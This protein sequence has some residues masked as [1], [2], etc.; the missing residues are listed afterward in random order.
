MKKRLLAC[1]LTLSMVAVTV[2]GCGKAKDQ[3]NSQT[4]TETTPTTAVES[5][6]TT[7]PA[8]AEPSKYQTTYGSKMFDDVTITVELF[9]RS[10]APEGSTITDNRWTEYVQQEMKKVGINVE[11]VTV[12]RWDEVTKMQT[13]MASGTAPDITLT[14]T[15]AY[16]EQYLND[17]GI[18]DLSEFINADDQATNMKAY[19][20]ED[21]LNIGKTQDNQLY[22]IVA[23]RATTAKSNLF[24]RKDWLDKL[25][26]TVPTTPDELYNV[27]YAMKYSN[28]DA[29]NS[30]I[31]AIISNAWNM[32]LAFSQ[33]AGNEKEAAISFGD[34]AIGD[35]YD[36]GNRE[37]YRFMNKLY[38]DGLLNK[39]YY[40]MTD[41]NFKSYIATGDVAFFES[42][43]NFAVD[44][45]RGSLLKTLQENVPDADIVS[46][47]PLKNAFDGKQYS[48]SYA[49]GGLIAF[50]PLTAD[51]DKV[52]ACMTYL[53]WQCTQDGGF[54]LYHG[55]EGEHF[56]Y[57]ADG[58]PVVIDA[59]FNATDK[60][61]IR[62][63][64]F[65]VGNQGY[66]NSVDDFNACTSKEAPGYE[67]HVVANYQNALTGTLVSDT[68]YTSP[69]TPDLLTDIG[70]V[71]DEYT[72]A[73][74]TCSKDEFDA[75]YDDYMAKLKAAGIQTIIDERT[76]YY[77]K[78]YGN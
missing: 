32:K 62:A 47:Q 74:V 69:S 17:G 40:T 31:G 9:D 42:S 51:A 36:P 7:E 38:N 71:R 43:V 10:N 16:A 28:P 44:V 61:W 52:E 41:D 21:V 1:L 18:W 46:I 58:V 26:L 23:K 20:G 14:Y 68:T 33:L 15:Y 59:T 48:A 76:E 45:M 49:S 37:Y 35:Y 19:L 53:D 67:D 13:M 24:I 29:K 39:E 77:N 73:S 8:T 54:T 6:T 22:G 75:T 55:I 11:F 66:F 63:D 60:D 57:D 2:T 25:N 56:N 30:T 5:G 70:L 50:C 72:V 64:L 3:D 4:S 78:V 12:G 65:V 27:L 34:D